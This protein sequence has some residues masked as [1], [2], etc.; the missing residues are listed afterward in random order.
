MHIHWIY[1]FVVAFLAPYLNIFSQNSNFEIKS[2]LK[3]SALA[4]KNAN[5]FWFISNVNGSK[6]K[7]TNLLF[8]GESLASYNITETSKI[9]AGVGFF[10]RDGFQ[11]SLQRNQVFLEYE[12]KYFLIVLGS[13]NPEVKRDGLSAVN[14]NFSMSGNARAIPG[15][16]IE[17]PKPILIF[18]NI[19]IDYGLGNYFLNDERAVHNT[20]IHYKKLGIQWKIDSKNTIYGG[21]Q[22]YAQYSGT[23]ST[24]GKQPNSFRD[25]L[26]VFLARRASN[27]TDN[28]ILNALGN[29]L[30]FYNLK[31]NYQSTF[32]D[33]QFYHQHPFEDGSGTALKNF[34]DGIWGL[35]YNVNSENQ[36]FIKSVLFEYIQTTSQSGGF[37]TTSGGDNYFNNGI[38]ESGWTYEKNTIGLPLLQ[39]ATNGRGIYNNRIKAIQFGATAQLK[40]FEFKSKWTLVQNF[41]TYAIPYTVRENAIYSYLETSYKAEKLGVFTVK[42]GYDY[43]NLEVD[44]FGA[45][46]SY[47]YSF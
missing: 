13:K 27:G 26:D 16:L 41:G 46:V 18:N 33:L 1:C 24:F 5:P 23:S 11:N 21:I 25:Y 29:H 4:S 6:A 34:P 3:L 17:A 15:I 47:S 30:G 8:E 44:K 14:D 36:H 45:G 28:D 7:A 10:L 9:S 42:A 37:N 38:Y 39:A 40:K 19:Y 35:Y 43:S 31:Y 2:T 12:N 32:G 22:H 20:N